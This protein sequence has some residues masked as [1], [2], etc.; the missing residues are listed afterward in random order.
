M[1]DVIIIILVLYGGFRGYQKGLISQ[2]FIFMIF[3]MFFFKGFYIFDFIKKIL[4]E[5]NIVNEKSYIFIIYSLIITL[6]SIIFI[7]F[8]TKK[9][10]EFIMIVTWMKPI[11]RLGGV[12]L[13]MIKYFFCLSI[14]IFLLKEA[15][16]KI[17]LFPYNFLQSSFEKEFQ[18]FFSQKESLLNKLNKLKELY[19]KFYEF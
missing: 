13:G 14:C 12:I 7:T 9:I 18:F 17:D 6:F 2:F 11:D 4:K 5:V 3:F 16:K 10:I 8:I 19:F 15:N 1:L